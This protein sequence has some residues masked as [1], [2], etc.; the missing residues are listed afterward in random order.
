MLASSKADRISFDLVLD[1]ALIRER[2]HLRGAHQDHLV[3]FR[4]LCR[5]AP[6]RVAPHVLLGAGD[7]G[8]E[9]EAVRAA[10]RADVPCLVLLSLLGRKVG[11]WEERLIR[12]V[13]ECREQ[14]RPVLLGC[15][16]PR[17][18][19][20]VEMAALEAGAAGIANPSKGTLNAIRERGWSILESS[21]CCA[22]H[23]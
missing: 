17:G 18:R 6:G 20:D 11:G 16:R 3:S 1:P 7:E 13:E 8:C 5:A 14:H 2:M 19:P 15:M 22:L 21:V 9:L 12:A 4:A 23:R 10:C